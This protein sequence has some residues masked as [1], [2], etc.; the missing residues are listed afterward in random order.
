MSQSP[1]LVWLRRDLR[2]ADHP[3]L[4]AAVETGRPVIPLFIHAA[5]GLGAAAEWRLGQAVEAMAKQLAAIGSR[6]ILRQGDAKQV[7][8]QVIADTG[9][10]DVYWMRQYDPACV[11]RDTALKTALSD[12]GVTARSFP[13]FLLHEPWTVAT[14]QGGP[15]KVYTPYWRAVRG[16]DVPAPLPAPGKLP[17]PKEWPDSAAFDDL[18]MGQAMN[19]GAAVL[20]QYSQAGEQAAQD[21]LAAFL[22][23]PIADYANARDNLGQP[24]ASDLSAALTTGEI[25][26]R[27]LW[28]AGQRAREEGA[29]GAEVFLKQLV[30]RDFAWHLLW[31]FPQLPANCWRPEWEDFPWATDPQTPEVQAWQQGRT[32]VDIVDAAMRELFVT[33][34][35]HN[36]ARMIVASYLTKHLLVDWRIGAAWF[37]DCL[38]DW[39]AASNAMGWQWVAGCGPDA[40]PYFRVF[41][42]ETQAQK[43]DPKGA[44]RRRWLAEGQASPPDSARAFYKAAPRRW[45]LGAHDAP[46]TPTATLAE[47]RLRALAAYERWKESRG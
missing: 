31:H 42:P 25:S 29:Q 17:A 34:R 32:G 13:G 44:Y 14:G 22:D 45:R 36:R 1:V 18:N 26:I 11:D 24:G 47:G 3:A 39:D 12:Q 16:R 33:G 30:W 6:L 38:C 28:H 27:T 41:N 23:G 20:A 35:M 37:A 10:T 19:R 8:E 40:S 15:Y 43:F 9:A 21:Q 5:D 2:L 46:A 4:T 7:L